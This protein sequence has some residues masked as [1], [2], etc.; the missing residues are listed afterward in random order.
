V[1]AFSLNGQTSVLYGGQMSSVL[2]AQ[3]K[4]Q[5]V[6]QG[7]NV[8]ALLR[9]ANQLT[10]SS[11]LNGTQGRIKDAKNTPLDHIP[12]TFGRT[13]LTYQNGRVQAE[14][15]ALYNGW[16]RIADY[17]PEGEDNAQYATPDGMP[18]WTTLNVRGS[19]KA[20]P[21]LTVQAAL[22]NILDRN[23]RYFASGIS[24]PGR[25]LTLTVRSAF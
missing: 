19:F 20:G 2:A 21:Y 22:E 16:K 24:A 7:W 5:A 15:W 23:Y 1:D 11:T 13:A 9:L 25:N 17:N 12:P 3:N 18:A 10:L 6:I 8:A 4:R 14:V